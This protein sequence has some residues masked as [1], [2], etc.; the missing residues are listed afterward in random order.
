MNDL[1]RQ[2]IALETIKILKR[3]F[4]SFPTDSASSRNAPFHRA[5]LNA[6][7]DKI[8][9]AGTSISSFINLSSWMHGLNTTL[10][11]TFFESA[12]N[13]LCEGEK[14]TFSGNAYFE[15]QAIAISEHM[16]DLK[17]GERTPSV[18]E[19][20]ALLMEN[21]HGEIIPAPNFTADCFFEDDEKVV[22][23]EMKTVRPNSGE[24]RGEKQK[25]L[26]GKAV[27]MRLYPKKDVYYY[28][29]FPFD[30]LSDTNTGFCKERFMK[31]IADYIK[32]CDSEEVL[33]ADELWSFL[34]GENGTM[35]QLLDIINAVATVDFMTKY[36]ILSDSGSIR[37]KNKEYREIA[38][39]WG[40]V[41]ELKIASNIAALSALRDK[42]ITRNIAKPAFNE[43]GEYNE[44]RARALLGAL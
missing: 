44:K 34:S 39:E 43:N 9:S 22:A 23:I 13:C 42:H 28:F 29:G 27:L 18:K 15:N 10:G 35:Q 8:D 4:D 14:R 37:A 19:E 30:P 1:T 26:I 36:G 7:R 21:A 2:Q 38:R 24:V 11:Q 32:F 33:L 12:A 40:L 5:F 25:I 31:S 3:R 20:N 41:D 6:F 16:T 17:N